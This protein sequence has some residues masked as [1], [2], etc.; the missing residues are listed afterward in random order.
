LCQHGSTR[1]LG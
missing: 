1:Q